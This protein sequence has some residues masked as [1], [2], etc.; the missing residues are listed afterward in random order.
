MRAIGVVGLAFLVHVAPAIAGPAPRPSAV[1]VSV[2]VAPNLADT[3]NPI[4]RV[5]VFNHGKRPI[6]VM[7][8]GGTID[9]TIEAQQPNGE[10]EEPMGGGCGNGFT[11]HR[12]AAGGSADYPLWA[13]LSWSPGRSA[14]YRIVVSY[15]EVGN[16]TAREVASDP[17]A[18]AFGDVA[19]KGK[20]PT[21]PGRVALV[22]A[23][24]SKS[25]PDAQSPAAIGAALLPAITACLAAGQ[26][27]LPWLRG[28]FTLEAYSYG[29]SKPVLY[30]GSQLLGDK[31]TVACLGAIPSPAVD[32]EVTMT[33]ALAPGLP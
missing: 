24:Q 28:Q 20:P 23:E 7:V 30:V 6:E 26:R 27:R 2:D 31:A 25:A 18:L 9:A 21:R 33:Y 19:P 13:L 8:F 3:P 5:F 22:S 10:F 16:S 14:T 15:T 29:G 17:F 11:P 12:I 1:S 4:P 32:G